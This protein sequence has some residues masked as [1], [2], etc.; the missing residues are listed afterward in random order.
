MS[1]LRKRQAEGISNFH[2]SRVKNWG[3]IPQDN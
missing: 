3:S 1:R 2:G